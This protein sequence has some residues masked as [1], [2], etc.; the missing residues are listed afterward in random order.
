MKFIKTFLISGLE[1]LLPPHTPPWLIYLIF[2]HAMYI[3]YLCVLCW[4]ALAK[5]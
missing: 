1:V 3:L 2:T 4:N 5:W